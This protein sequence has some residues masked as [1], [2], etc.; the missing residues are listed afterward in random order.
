MSGKRSLDFVVLDADRVSPRDALVCILR[1]L[2][3]FVGRRCWLLGQC[4]HLWSWLEPPDAIK[5]VGLGMILLQALS[6]LHVCVTFAFSRIFGS[7]IVIVVRPTV[8]RK[9][10]FLTSVCGMSEMGSSAVCSRRRHSGSHWFVR[11]LSLSVSWI[12]DI[13]LIQLLG[14]LYLTPVFLSYN[15]TVNASGSRR[16]SSSRLVCIT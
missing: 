15:T 3:R 1:R 13:V 9:L 16:L 10:V 7:I 8:P 5:G 2:L 12:R 11:L 6:H 14:S 4:L